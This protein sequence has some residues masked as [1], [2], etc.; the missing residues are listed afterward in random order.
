MR[1][2]IIFLT[3]FTFFVGGCASSSVHR[4]D[5]YSSD[6][7]SKVQQVR[8]GEILSIKKVVI[9]KNASGKNTNTILGGIGG[10]ALGGAVGSSVG[11]GS[12]RGVAT[13][14]GAIAGAVIGSQAQNMLEQSDGVELTIRLDDANVISVVQIAK[15]DEFK[16]TQ[17]V[18][19]IGSDSVK[20]VPLSN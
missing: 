17:R 11:S 10:G 12:G 16:Q 8:Y 9:Q 13:V 14:V 6:E 4:G 19:I 7:T 15:E 5:V 20:V 1:F 18:Q 3:I 2:Q